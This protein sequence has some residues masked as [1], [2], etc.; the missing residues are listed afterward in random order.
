MM[1][2]YCILFLFLACFPKKTKLTQLFCL[3]VHLLVCQL[4]FNNFEPVG[5]FQPGIE[6]DHKG[7][8]T[9]KFMHF[10]SLAVDKVLTPCFCGI[11]A[12]ILGSSN[13]GLT[14]GAVGS[15]QPPHIP[16]L[17]TRSFKRG[18]LLQNG[19]TP[20]NWEGRRPTQYG[21]Q[22]CVGSWASLLLLF[23]KCMYLWQRKKAC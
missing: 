11:P 16:S 10:Y 18:I 20:T 15:G 17:G 7:M 13:H 9:L 3:A 21:V 2:E 8:L 14:V 12:A 4:L 1:S 23:V 22:S 6:R 5:W 19:K